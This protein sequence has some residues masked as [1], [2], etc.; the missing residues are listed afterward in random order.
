MANVK[1][2][3]PAKKFNSNTFLFMITI[4]LFIVMY[5][6]GMIIFSEQIGRAHV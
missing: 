4:I 1:A 3:L 5:V 6:A 2:K